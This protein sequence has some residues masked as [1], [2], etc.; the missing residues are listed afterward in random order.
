MFVTQTAIVNRHVI[1]ESSCSVFELSISSTSARFIS[2]C[3]YSR[4]EGQAYLC[5]S[6]PTLSPL[7]AERFTPV[8]THFYEHLLRSDL[9]PFNEFIISRRPSPGLNTNTR[10]YVDSDRAPVNW[11]I[12][13][14]EW[15]KGSFRLDGLQKSTFFLNISPNYISSRMYC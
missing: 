11:I 1:I 6:V 9:R 10:M 8:R 5:I 7:P 3:K 2:I 14:T 13:W 15:V 12:P 4:K